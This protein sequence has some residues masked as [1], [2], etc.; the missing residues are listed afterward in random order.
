MRHIIFSLSLSFSLFPRFLFRSLGV[1]ADLFGADVDVPCRGAAVA[2]DRCL[3]LALSILVVCVVLLI[4]IC[5]AGDPG[6]SGVTRA[7]VGSI[8]QGVLFFTFFLSF[9]SLLLSFVSTFIV[10]FLSFLFIPLPPSR[11]FFSSV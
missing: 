9:S 4:A 7:P 11:F 8:F 3:V 6:L 5:A 1:V 2:G 10:L